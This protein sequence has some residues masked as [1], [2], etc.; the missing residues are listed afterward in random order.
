LPPLGK[1]FLATFGKIYYC[2]PLG[3]N[4]SDAHERRDFFIASTFVTGFVRSVVQ[5][6]ECTFRPRKEEG[7]F[8]KQ[9]TVKENRLLL[10]HTCKLRLKTTG[11]RSNYRNSNTRVICSIAL[12]VL[13]H[14]LR[15]MP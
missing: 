8:C 4:P 10:E 13:I 12:F 2:P 6:S 9:T 7:Q 1:I 15:T 3:K 11:E 14:M 5:Y